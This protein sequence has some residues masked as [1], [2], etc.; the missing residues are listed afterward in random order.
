MKKTALLILL[1]ALCLLVAPFAVA[2]GGPVVRSDALAAYTDGQ[3]H[4]YLPG[5][6]EAI[7][8]RTADSVVG[9]DAY[10]VLYLSP[11]GFTDTQ[12]LCVV[13]LQSLQ[14]SL[15][16]TDVKAACLANED[17]AYYVTGANRTKLNRVD[18]RS[19]TSQVVYTA[20]EP[21]DRL[22]MSAEGL[23]F[24]L[25]DQAATMLYDEQT[26][27]FEIYNGDMPRSG[28]TGEVMQVR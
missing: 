17:I 16:A 5:R 26:D 9:M 1:L 21:I 3:G 4:L 7:N 15:V 28:A 19:L 13:D 8:A 10:R 14:E 27:R 24:Q 20:A 23:I 6:A 25:V 2:E 22:Y 11:D 12:D 18:L